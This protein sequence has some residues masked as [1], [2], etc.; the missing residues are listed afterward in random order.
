MKYLKEW[1]LVALVSMVLMNCNPS[2]V[3]IPDNF[4]LELVGTWSRALVTYEFKNDGSYTYTNVNPLHN[5][6]WEIDKGVLMLHM[7]TGDWIE[8][9]YIITTD[10]D[11]AY[12]RG[13]RYEKQ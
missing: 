11:V 4:D 6:S 5:G 7:M 13:N 2:G 12:F 10:K 1:L 3:D 9:E 8:I